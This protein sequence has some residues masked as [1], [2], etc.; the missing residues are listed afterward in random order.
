MKKILAIALICALSLSMTACMS[1][2][3]SESSEAPSESSSSEMPEEESSET[4]EEDT[5]MTETEHYADQTQKAEDAI[6]GV[7]KSDEA[8]EMVNDIDGKLYAAYDAVKTA[9]GTDYIPSRV[10]ETQEL[11]EIYGLNADTIEYVI[12][13]GPMMSTHV[14]TFIAIKA[15]EGQGEVVETALNAYRDKL[16]SDTVQYPSN[17]PKIDAS[18]VIREGDYVFFSMVGSFYEM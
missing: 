1:S 13:E 2:E 3:E 4:P 9:M 7:I 15:V 5:E 17:L 6:M 10:I 14:D 11:T 16:V 18:K 12:A 8:Y